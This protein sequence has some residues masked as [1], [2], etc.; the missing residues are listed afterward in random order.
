MK[1]KPGMARAIWKGRIHTPMKITDIQIQHYAIPLDPP[2][3][4]AWDHNPRT[5]LGATIVKVLTDEGLVG[6]G[7]GDAMTGFEDYKHLFIGQDPF[8]I[9][10]HSLVLETIAFHGARHWPFENALWD[11]IARA[12]GQPLY[13]LLGGK[14]NRLLAYCSTGEL[15]EPAEFVAHA[16]QIR[17]R[18]FK[19]V[20][21]RFHRPDPREDLAVVEAVRAAVGHSMEI[22]VD[23]NQAWRMPG[24]TRP[25]WT[26]K[27]A[28]MVARELE[29]Y[30]VYWLEEPLHIHD[31]EG[32][33][34]LRRSTSVRI[35]GGELNRSF[36]DYRE[37]VAHGSLDV[38]QPDVVVAGGILQCKKV[39]ALCDQHNLAFSP[40]TWGN[41]I[42]LLANLHLAAG[43]G[44]CPYLELPYDP[45]RFTPA[46]RDF[47]LKSPVDIDAEGYINLPDEPGMGIELNPD[48]EQYRVN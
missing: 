37:Y 17:E 36:A 31:F 40:H 39:A 11:L 29:R 3:H 18:G 21:I 9:E 2:Y 38:L 41:G 7:S 12:A 32:L 30:G 24:D 44:I 23:A 6:I 15:R 19:A 35:A 48:L 47:M 13:K 8:A 25:A 28:W 20:K 16:R 34:E 45:P 10:R 4:A 43:T 1:P 42:G 26:R 22:M 46:H 33:A 27:T 5:K 14:S